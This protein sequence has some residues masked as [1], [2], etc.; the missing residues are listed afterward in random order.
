M[1]SSFSAKLREE[2]AAR[3]RDETSISRAAK[4][5]LS[6]TPTVSVTANSISFGGAYRSNVQVSDS[7]DDGE[8]YDIEPTANIYRREGGPS[9]L[10]SHIKKDA[11]DNLR[12]DV[13]GD[14]LDPPPSSSSSSSSVATRSTAP[15]D[16]NIPP[17][18]LY[19]SNNGPMWLSADDSSES[20]PQHSSSR[21]PRLNRSAVAA[22]L[23]DDCKTT[24]QVEDLRKDLAQKEKDKRL[25]EVQASIQAKEKEDE[26]RTEMD[27]KERELASMVCFDYFPHFVA[28]LCLSF[29]SLSDLI[30]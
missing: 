25:A 1:T 10:T 17:P 26:M 13:L 3:L 11:I 7:D 21:G 23:D 27:R 16:P 22:A 15:T 6:Y 5:A 8:G 2:Q 20:K 28:A 18:S 9:K 24:K 14:M 19:S 12:K 4:N 30:Q 29:F